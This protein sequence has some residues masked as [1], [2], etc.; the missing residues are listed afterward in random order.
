ML[1]MDKPSGERPL[2]D[3]AAPLLT[4]LLRNLKMRNY[5]F[6][7]PTPATHARVLAR[8]RHERA[9]SLRDIFGWSM[10]FAPSLL[11]PGLLCALE[12][13]GLIVQEGD[14]LISRVRVSSLGD[15]LFLHSAYP[16]SG[17]DAVFF[18]PDSYRFARLIEEELA[19]C[20]Q[21]RSARLVDI[22]TGAGVGGI[23]AAKACPF[24]NI[25]LTD[26]NPAA[27]H[28]A[29]VNAAGAGV[30]ASFHQAGDLAALDG[31]F[32]VALANPP[33][34]VDGEG[35]AYRDGGG[36]HGGA[37]SIDMAGQA[38][39]RLA[40]GGR[41]ILYTGSAIVDGRD[42]LRERLADLAH[43]QDCTLRYSEIDP[44]V[45]GEELETPAYEHVERIALV[46]AIIVRGA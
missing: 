41:F 8:R 17:Q 44:D 21:R 16:T 37:V 28:L 35:R 18:G 2:L 43:R 45:F 10:R 34:I 46:A 31:A 38:V 25:I 7:T 27:L 1:V 6:I 5:H 3:D 11:D 15:D 40:P 33:Y 13:A 19:R 14:A 32:D 20:P 12:Q 22:G 30:E 29:R 4:D 42:A 36:M 23:V 24:A 9:R 39:P 26:I